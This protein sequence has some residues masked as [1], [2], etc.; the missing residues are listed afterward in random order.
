MYM[1]WLLA[2]ER[3]AAAV[4]RVTVEEI[5]AAQEEAPRRLP[6][7]PPDIAWT[8]GVTSEGESSLYRTC[9]LS[10][11]SRLSRC[12]SRFATSSPSSGAAG[13]RS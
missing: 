1:P 4:S 3:M 6:K 9:P 11:Q 7:P 5:I 12:S 10:D 13:P 2:L 8:T